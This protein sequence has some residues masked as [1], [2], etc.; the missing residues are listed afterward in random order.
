[1]S[2][3]EQETVHQSWTLDELTED[4]SAHLAWLETSRAERVILS[5]SA[6]HLRPEWRE[7]LENWMG[8]A[9]GRV[10][11]LV[12]LS[13]TGRECPAMRLVAAKAAESGVTCEYASFLQSPRPW[14]GRSSRWGINE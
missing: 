10:R 13:A 8:W 1:M 6:G 12:I 9:A 11:S 14:R 5:L 2:G 4:S 7:A 3:D